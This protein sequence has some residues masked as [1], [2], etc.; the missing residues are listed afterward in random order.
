MY[1]QN[2]G[3]EIP[4]GYKFCFNCGAPVSGE[5]TG[6]SNQNS[7]LSHPFPSQ[8]AA[9]EQ[10]RPP[11]KPKKPKNWPQRRRNWKRN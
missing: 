7:G 4:E 11:K 8:H 9:F 6:T 2:C 5:I 1:C 10:P 3:S